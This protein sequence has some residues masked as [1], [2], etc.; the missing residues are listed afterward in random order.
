MD[1]G[2]DAAPTPGWRIPISGMIPAPRDDIEPDLPPVTRTEPEGWVQYGP[3]LVIHYRDGQSVEVRARAPAGMHCADIPRWAGFLD[4]GFPMLGLDNCVWPGMSSV[5]R[6]AWGLAAEV[7]LASGVFDV[8]VSRP[9]HFD[10][11]PR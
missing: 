9:G 2:A 11:R 1:A 8:W 4:A 3:D 10:D 7:D 6:M 5:H